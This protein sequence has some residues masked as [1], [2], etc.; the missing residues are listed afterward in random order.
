MKKLI[1]ALCAVCFV[2]CATTD[3]YTGEKKTS[4]AGKGGGIGA[5][6]GA[7]AGAA[8]SSKKDRN[9]GALTGALVGAAVGGGIGHYMD[10]Q[11]QVMR[12]RL[13]GSGVQVQREGNNLNLIMPGNI[14]FAT[15][16][17]EIR[18]D[19]YDVLN[20]VVLVLKEYN[21]TN[22][23]ISGHTDS[24]GSDKINQKLSE[25][26]ASSVR[27]YLIGQQINSSRI[28]AVGYGSHSPIASNDTEAGR[29][30]NRRVEMQLIPVE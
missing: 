5:V 19:F 15:N 11:E 26:R 14:T 27:S 2:G 1:I 7:V 3:P 10:K 4:N 6:V 22:I 9:R 13:Q 20:S 8:A 30:A 21:K 29:Q 23:N 18:A 17:S 16:R 25:D 24:T 28:D 12:D